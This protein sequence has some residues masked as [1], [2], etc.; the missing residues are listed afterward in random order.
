MGTISE[1]IFSRAA[2]KEAKAN[3]FVLAD[4]DYAMAHDGTSVLAVN[5]F[6]EMEMEKV[7]DP[8]KIVIP[9]DHIAPANTETSAILQKE[10][11][12]WVQEQGIPNFY[13]VGEGI[14]HQVLPEN[15]FALPGK[16][17]VG[18][19]S[20]SCTYGAFGAFAT[21]VGATDMAEIFATGKLWF[22][23]P[24]S[25]RM[26][27]EGS[28]EKNVYAKDLTLY[29]IGKTGIAGA[30]YKA[31]EFYGQAISELSVSGRMTLCNM[32]IEMGAKTGIV[33]PDEKT[34]DFLKNRAVAPY[35]PVYTD[36][37]A[38][39]AGEFTYDAGDIEPQV[40]CPHQVDN[41]KPVGEVEGTHVD[42]V[43]I[44]TCTNGRLEDLEVAA[45][46]L[47]GKKVAVRTLVIPASR[48]TLLAAIENGTM[49]TLL[50]AGVTL[51]TPGC[52]PCLGAHQGVIGEG[53]VCIST[54]NRN[55]KGRM[56]KGGFIYLASPVT[57]AA[58]ALTG[59]I[60]DPRTI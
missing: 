60:T 31:V 51:T 28:L 27:V 18:A 46:V 58:S 26:T 32:A 59:E 2:G 55:F 29:L 48:T 33:P 16:L 36:P 8:S 1:K 40:A 21:G 5:A 3:D 56:G 37:D 34:F 35:E 41:V 39:Y 24:E 47:K 13:E 45:E 20:H 23:V 17:V 53:E 14:C 57:A 15:G 43:F 4:V 54:A 6:K 10:I 22:K 12:E 11:R 19:D 7:W 42:Q 49:E 38:T 52:G 9:F 50:K 30:T 25:F 44:G